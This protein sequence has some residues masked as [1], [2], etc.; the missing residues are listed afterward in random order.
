MILEFFATYC[1]SCV[2]EIPHLKT[3]QHTRTL[4]QA[5]VI[6]AVS[7]WDQDTNERLGQFRDDYDIPWILARDTAN[8]RRDYGVSALPT[9]FVIDQDGYV[10]Y[11][12]IDV[13]VEAYV[14]MK[15]VSRLLADIN[16]DD[17]IDISD[18]SIAAVAYG[19]RAGQS[20]YDPAADVNHDRIIDARDTAIIAWNWGETIP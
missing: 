20:G 14:F 18:L 2:D 10:A 4:N 6:I 13:I 12:H 7:I 11:E 5:F 1:G 3:V 15:E 17:L 9:L 16:G 19:R 8:V